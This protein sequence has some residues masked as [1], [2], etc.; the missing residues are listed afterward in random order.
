MR[1]HI[2]FI[3]ICFSITGISSRNIPAMQHNLF[4]EN[5][6]NFLN[7]SIKEVPGTDEFKPFNENSD[8]A[9]PAG[10]LEQFA[11]ESQQGC[12]RSCSLRPGNLEQIR[13]KELYW[14]LGILAVT[15][16]T[17]FLV[18]FK[19]SR[20][21]RNIFLFLSVIILGFSDLHHA[22]PCMLSSLQ[23]TVLFIFGI[24]TDWQKMLWFIGL[25]PVT[26]LFGKVWCGWLCHL[27]ALQEF[28][29]LP[30]KFNIF[31]G[32]KAMKIMKIIRWILLLTLIIQLAIEQRIFFCRIDPFKTIFD[33]DIYGSRFLVLRWILVGLLLLT[34]FFSYRPFCKSACPVGLMLGLISFIPGSSVIGRKGDCTGCELCHAT[35]RQ[36]AIL[37][38]KEHIIL[39]NI[40]CISCGKCLDSCRNG[41]LGFFRKKKNH[42]VKN[43]LKYF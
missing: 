12:S 40:D 5:A 26:Y 16:I 21:L 1:F 8:S 6:N 3:S 2:F 10:E 17:G 7:D 30:I 24:N 15:V 32:E 13:R 31:K 11:N 4:A 42:P 34:S 22:C 29:F 23:D 35:C 39:N 27:G 28:L 36:E 38:K 43:F 41:G 20:N 18:R 19:L 9:F 33:L 14:V 25:I 37:C